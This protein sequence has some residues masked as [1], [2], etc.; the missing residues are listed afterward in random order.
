MSTPRSICNQCSDVGFTLV[1]FASLG[2]LSLYLAG[3]TCLFVRLSR[4]SFHTT[5][6]L[7]LTL[8]FQDAR[9]YASKA[10]V[11]VTPFICVTIIAILSTMDRRHH[12]EDDTPASVLGL[13]FAL[14]IYQQYYPPL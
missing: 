9:G 13:V 10:L 1:S 14:F 5:V 12:W 6:V 11:T 2:F 8:A 7:R 3:K 4:P